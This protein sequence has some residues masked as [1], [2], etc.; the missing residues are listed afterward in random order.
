LQAWQAYYRAALP[1]LEHRQSPA[2]EVLA[3]LGGFDAPLAELREA[4]ATRP[5]SRFPIYEDGVATPLWHITALQQ[6]EKVI[7]LRA[8]AELRLNRSGDALADMQIGFRLFDSIRDEPFLIS[9]LVRVSVAA[10]LMGPVWEGIASH[11]WTDAQLVILQTQ[12]QQMNFLPD[13]L[14]SLRMERAESSVRMSAI[15]EDPHLA[16]EYGIM[17]FWKGWIYQSEIIAARETQQLLESVDIRNQ[18]VDMQQ[19]K[20]NEESLQDRVSR[21][22]PYTAL[23]AVSLPVL[24]EALRKSALMQTWVNEAVIACDIER[25]RLAHGTLPAT[26]DELHMT[27]LPRDIINGQPL[28]YR[29]KGTDDYLLY[30]VGW[31]EADNGG[32]IVRENDGRPDWQKS[33]WV[34]SLKPL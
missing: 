15:Y 29:V 2:E 5:L 30:S 32:K 12:L 16:N 8:E 23:A 19:V 4:M 6:L 11:R 25:Y 14:R 27:G 21:H 1:K 33:D 22:A 9:E 7:A 26:L 17:R 34:W 31:K 20:R 18:R 13:Y 10:I 3:A 24:S 28:H